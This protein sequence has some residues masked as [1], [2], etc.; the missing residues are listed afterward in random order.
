MR[1]L[2]NSAYAQ[3][4]S[5]IEIKRETQQGPDEEELRL[6]NFTLKVAQEGQTK[7]ATEESKEGAKAAAGEKSKDGEEAEQ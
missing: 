5:L 3:N 6:S 2:E 1:N 4:P 7:P